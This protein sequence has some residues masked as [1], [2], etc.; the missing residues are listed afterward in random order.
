M[1]RGKPRLLHG[2]YVNMTHKQSSN[3]YP[4]AG[5]KAKASPRDYIP[6]QTC[7]SKRNNLPYHT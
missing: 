3:H 2:N 7:S 4:Q 1:L 6:Q 5:R